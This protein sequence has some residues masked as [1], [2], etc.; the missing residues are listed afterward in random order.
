MKAFF[1]NDT[2]LDLTNINNTHLMQAFLKNPAALNSAIF[3]T[4]N[5][6]LVKA[7]I[8]KDMPNLTNTAK[9]TITFNI[10]DSDPT[11]IVQTINYKAVA[12]LV[13]V[14]FNSKQIVKTYPVKESD[15]QLDDSK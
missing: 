13:Q 8:N 5:A 4:N 11:T 12:K 10:P 14:D 1:Y 6:D 7:T 9:R 15:W 3:I 2:K